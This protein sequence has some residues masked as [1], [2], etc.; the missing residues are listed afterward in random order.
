MEKAIK[1]KFLRKQLRR[2]VPK[3]R[4]IFFS[5][6]IFVYLPLHLYFSPILHFSGDKKVRGK[7][8]NLPNEVDERSKTSQ[9]LL[10]PSFSPFLIFFP[11]PDMKNPI[12]GKESRYLRA[13]RSWNPMMRPRLADSGSL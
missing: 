12:L 5:R 1:V 8:K 7:K 13:R 6:F 11:L 2:I 4:Y 3:S 10:F 9:T